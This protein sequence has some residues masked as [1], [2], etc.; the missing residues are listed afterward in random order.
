VGNSKDDKEEEQ[1]SQNWSHLLLLAQEL[2]RHLRKSRE[3]DKEGLPL[4]E[5]GGAQEE[6]ENNTIYTIRRRKK[7][8]SSNDPH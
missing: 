4:I 5:N 3:R 1:M 6:A 8:N 7:P 2:H